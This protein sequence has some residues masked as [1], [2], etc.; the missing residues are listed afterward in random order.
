M[1]CVAR[2]DGTDDSIK[3]YVVRLYAFDH[4][5][6]ERRH[7]EVAAFDNEAEALACFGRTHF[8][9]LERSQSGRVDPREHVTIIVKE[10]GHGE[11]MRARR[12]EWNRMLRR[13]RHDR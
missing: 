1:G 11:C 13:S 12:L 6:H 8:D 4:T 3:R 10:P 7:Q 9:L 2:V 5:R